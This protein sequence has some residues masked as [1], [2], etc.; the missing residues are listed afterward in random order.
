MRIACSFEPAILIYFYR[1]VISQPQLYTTIYDSIL[2]AIYC[3][4]ASV[5]EYNIWLKISIVTF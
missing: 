1:G 2:L 4:A 5:H 3:K